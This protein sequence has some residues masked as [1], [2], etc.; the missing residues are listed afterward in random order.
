MY[1]GETQLSSKT[2]RLC[3]IVVLLGFSRLHFENTAIKVSAIQ[4][5]SE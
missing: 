5:T 3:E 2:P 1:T 4:C